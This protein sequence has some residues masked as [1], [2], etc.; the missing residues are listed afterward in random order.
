MENG[1]WKMDNLLLL[2]L[3]LFTVH[4][5]LLTVQ[6]QVAV[7]GETVWTMAGEPISNGVVLVNN[8]KIEAVGTAQQIKIPGNYRVI[9]AKVVTPGLIDARTVVG[10]SGYMNQPHDQMQ[11]DASS[12]MQP[13]L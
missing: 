9:N 13:E 8:G 12:P 11:I 6:A 10:L 3:T 1:K 5:S 7:K 2:A 4:F